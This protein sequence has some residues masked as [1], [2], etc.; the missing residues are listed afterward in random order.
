M[1]GLR[2]WD[3]QIAQQLTFRLH[4]PLDVCCGV[5]YHAGM[6]TNYTSITTHVGGLRCQSRFDSSG[7]TFVTDVDSAMGGQGIYPS[8][9]QMLAC[10]VASC[11]LSMIAYT[12]AQKEFE[13]E[14]I[15]IE[16]GYESSGKGI[17]ALNFNITVPVATSPVVRRFMEA[18]ANNCPVGN[19]LA[20]EVEKRI[21]WHWAE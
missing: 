11:M 21:H 13:T 8:P 1:S 10:S 16:A 5:G 7:A 3:R 20:A 19:A 6:D 18:A 9:A 14:G 12:G 17:T 15:S 2:R 4:Y